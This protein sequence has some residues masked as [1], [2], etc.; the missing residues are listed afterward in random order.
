MS[1]ITVPLSS[2]M[3]SQKFESMD[4]TSY[5]EVKDADY[6]PGDIIDTGYDR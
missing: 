6:I 2:A 4:L 3:S 5:D 1:T